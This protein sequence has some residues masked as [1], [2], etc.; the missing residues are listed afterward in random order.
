MGAPNR[1]L[2]GGKVVMATASELKG[3]LEG[4]SRS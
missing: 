1:E 4:C 2:G 3:G